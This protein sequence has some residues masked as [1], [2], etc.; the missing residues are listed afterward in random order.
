MLTENIK[1]EKKKFTADF[2]FYAELNDFLPAHQRQQ[3]L[4]YRFNGNPGI[5]DPIEVFGVPHTEVDLIIVKGR[6][7]GFDYQL[8][9]TDRVAVYPVFE[10]FD[11]SPVIKLRAKPLRLT[12]FVVD[13]NL[14]KLARL[15]RMLGFDAL[16]SNT[17]LDHEIVEISVREKRIILTRDRRLLYAKCI[18]HG[19]WV[20]SVY[21]QKQLVEVLSRFDLYNQVQSF[22]RCLVCNGVLMPV[23][24]QQVWAQLEPKT[25]QY[26]QYFY[27]CRRCKKIYWEGSHVKKMQKR[28]KTIVP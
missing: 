17:Y 8:Q 4:N 3:T 20:R 6:S 14:G 11:I 5:K 13:V 25:K 22:H 9:D 15:L 23:D 7:V 19:Y 10:G 18:T 2:R 24:K 28:L 26:Y 21:P 16:Y 12:A 27:Q 1:G